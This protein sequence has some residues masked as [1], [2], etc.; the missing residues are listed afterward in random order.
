MQIER[1]RILLD[2]LRQKTLAN[3]LERAGVAKE[4]RLV[5]GQ[6]IDERCP[7]DGPTSSVKHVVVVGLIVRV[8]ELSHPYSQTRD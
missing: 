3:Q 1:W 4:S 5:D 6:P 8:T 2:P 7:L